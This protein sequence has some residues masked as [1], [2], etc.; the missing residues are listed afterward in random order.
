VADVIVCLLIVFYSH[1]KRILTDF[2][3]RFVSYVL[4]F[5]ST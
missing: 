2:L 4:H 3:L 1:R 5:C